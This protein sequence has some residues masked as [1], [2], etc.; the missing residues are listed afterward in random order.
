[1]KQLRAD[2]LASK[3]AVKEQNEE[4]QA[5]ER[6]TEPSPEP[7]APKEKKQRKPRAPRKRKTLVTEDEPVPVPPVT[8]T[9]V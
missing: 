7:S 2:S 8:I 5:E 9:W 6:P 1:M 3:R 4:K